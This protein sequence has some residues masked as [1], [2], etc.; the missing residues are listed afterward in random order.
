MS[1]VFLFSYRQNLYKFK[2]IVNKEIDYCHFYRHYR[3]CCDVHCDVRCGG[4]YA[5]WFSSCRLF[6]IQYIKY[7][8]AAAA[9]SAMDY[10]QVAL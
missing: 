2:A 3:P 6:I 1:C 10:E 9:S 7:S 5:S 8:A 4:L